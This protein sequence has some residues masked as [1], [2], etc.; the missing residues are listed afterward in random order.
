MLPGEPLRR[1][2]KRSVETQDFRCCKATDGHRTEGPVGQGR[3]ES[4]PTEAPAKPEPPTAKRRIS[5]EGMKR[6]IAATKKRWRLAKA[7]KA[8]SAA[9]KK[10]GPKKGAAKPAQR[11]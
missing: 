9:V 6:I 2:S 5:E 3:G 8:Q 10:A 4:V 11:R 1:A 7:A